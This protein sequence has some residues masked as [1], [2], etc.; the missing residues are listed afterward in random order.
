[1][2]RPLLATFLRFLVVGSLVT[3]ANY[4]AFTGLVRVGLHY[5]PSAT[6]AWALGVVLN[7][8]LSRTFTFAAKD[9]AHPREFGAFVSGNLLQ[10]G[11]GLAFYWL[12]IDA[13]GL[14]PTIAFL[15][16]GAAMAAF[17]FVFQR[18][19]VFPAKTSAKAV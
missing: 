16:N 15:A 10:L 14:S 13:L 7:Y 18:W 17:S 9:S 3:G 2:S 8:G 1:M 6:A 5:L 11:M 12:L 4:L 19:V